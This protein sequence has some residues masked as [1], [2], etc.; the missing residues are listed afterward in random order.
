MTQTLNLTFMSGS[1][2]G[3]VVQLATVNLDW[4]GCALRALDHR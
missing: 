3:E 2:D 1:L 4:S